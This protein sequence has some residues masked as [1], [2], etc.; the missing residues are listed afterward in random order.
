MARKKKDKEIEKKIDKVEVQKE[1]PAKLAL[2]KE[3][4]KLNFFIA[5]AEE[6]QLNR[7]GQAHKV[8]SGLKARLLKE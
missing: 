1:S 6:Y 2:K 7:I 8:L 5:V 3:I 4:E